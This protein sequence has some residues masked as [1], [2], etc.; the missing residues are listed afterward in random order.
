VA[1]LSIGTAVGSGFGLIKRRPL[2]VFVWGLLTVVPAAASMGAILPMMSEFMTMASQ[3]DPDS[4]TASGA[5][6]A[7]AMR[8]QGLFSLMGLVRL[9]LGVVTYT[10]IIRAVVRPKAHGFFFLRVGMDELREFVVSLAIIVGVVVAVIVVSILAAITGAVVWQAGGAIRA[11]VIAALVIGGLVGALLIGARLSLL[12][13][14]TVRFQTF[15]FAEGWA[16]GKG[17]TW[18]LVGLVLILILIVFGIEMVVSGVLGAVRFMTLGSGFGP[19]AWASGADPFASVLALA[20]ANW[21]WLAVGLVI[22]A[23]IYGMLTAILTAPFAS[24]VRQLSP[25]PDTTAAS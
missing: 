6:M 9:V 14:A 2:S 20:R 18:S 1:N 4:G 23:A 22:G 8:M 21:P 24:A 15:A 17:R 3:A 5:M 16:L 7:E 13:P 12:V 11:L 10:A 19:D 25:D